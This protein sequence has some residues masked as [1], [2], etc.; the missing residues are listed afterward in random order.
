MLLRLFGQTTL[1]RNFSNKR[2][3]RGNNMI[4]I[5]SHGSIPITSDGL[6]DRAREHIP[7][8]RDK[9]IIGED[10]AKGSIKPTK[11]IVGW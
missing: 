7:N 5:P 2:I 3:G 6:R 1:R 10:T 4:P 8:T 11:E 9:P